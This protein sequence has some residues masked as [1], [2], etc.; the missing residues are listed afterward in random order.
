MHAPYDS[1]RHILISL[2]TPD[3]DLMASAARELVWDVDHSTML[4]ANLT[5]DQLAALM[6]QPIPQGRN[7]GRRHHRQPG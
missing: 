7:Q 5:P 1:Q 3:A 2:P 4:Q 6:L